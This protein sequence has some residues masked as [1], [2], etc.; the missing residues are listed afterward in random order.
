M[1]PAYNNVFYF[2][3]VRADGTDSFTGHYFNISDASSTTTSLATAARSTASSTSLST[4]SFTSSGS[5]RLITPQSTLPATVAAPASKNGE[6]PVGTIAGMVVGIV[7]GSLLLIGGARW[8]WNV[9]K[10]RNT[11]SRSQPP[12]VTSG[13]PYIYRDQEPYEADKNQAYE[14]NESVWRPVHELHESA[15]RPFHELHGS[16]RQSRN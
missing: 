9:K 8:A 3:V 1:D 5:S 6:I 12:N 11:A 4:A 14:L 13:Q 16:V 15:E 2:S 10:R 7:F